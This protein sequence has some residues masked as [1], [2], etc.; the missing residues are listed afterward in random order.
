MPVLLL[1]LLWG[2]LCGSGGKVPRIFQSFEICDLGAMVSVMAVYAT[3]STRVI[4]FN[5]IPPL[6]SV[7]IAPLGVF[8]PLVL[9]APRGLVLWGMIP[10]LTG[11]V[12]IPIL[13]FPPVIVCWMRWVGSIQL[14]KI[15][16]LLSSGRLNTIHP[17]MGMWGRNGLWRTREGEVWILW[18]Y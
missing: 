10:A 14:F 17:R 16:V 15:L 7:V 1:C 2:R 3:K 9:V 6:A 11:I 8:V 18:W 4:G 5:S 12:I 13:P